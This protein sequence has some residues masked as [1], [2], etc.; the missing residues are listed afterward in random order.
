MKYSIFETDEAAPSSSYHYATYNSSLDPDLL[1][2]M[3]MLKS[4]FYEHHL[5]NIDIIID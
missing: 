2:D 4:W 3:N 1:A 5:E